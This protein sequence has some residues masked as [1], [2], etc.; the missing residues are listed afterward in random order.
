MNEQE[1]D[2]LEVNPDLCTGCGLCMAACSLQHDGE[3][4]ISASRV[5]VLVDDHKGMSMPVVCMQCVDAPCMAICPKKAISRDS[6]SGAYVVN[7]EL[8]IGCRLCV[9]VCPVGGI[10]FNLRKARHALKC[11]LCD[12]DPRC[13]R[14]CAP[15]AISLTK[16]GRVGEAQRRKVFSKYIETAENAGGKTAP[17]VDDHNHGAPPPK[18]QA[19]PKAEAPAAPEVEAKPDAEAPI[20]NLAKGTGKIPSQAEAQKRKPSAAY[21]RG[22]DG[23]S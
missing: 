5:K 21:L 4:S 16:P 11:D 19:A 22:A 2:L 10:S 23:K 14:F 18:A 15:H 6:R 3:C 1:H 12:G 9:L 8:C 13:V 7:A 17:V 20:Q